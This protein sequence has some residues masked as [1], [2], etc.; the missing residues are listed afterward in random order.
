M[1]II[2]IGGGDKT[3]AVKEALNRTGSEHPSVLLIP[4]ACSTENSYNKKVP[5]LKAFFTQLGVEGTALHEFNK[6]PS[7]DEIAEKIGQ[8]ALLYTIGGNTPFMI[9]TMQEH[10][11][12]TMIKTAIE[13][14]K[15]HAGVSAGALLPFEL[16]HS[17]IAAKPAETDWDY[18]Y[19]PGLGIIPG[20]ATAHADSHDPTPY[21][22]RP[23]SRL[24]ALLNTF[25][26]TIQTG[27]AIDNGAALVFS[28]NS[29]AVITSSPTARVHTIRHSPNNT[30]SYRATEI[31][32]LRLS[33]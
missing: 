23:D 21:G 9:R 14:G 25:P 17:C 27:Y 20:V 10:G 13:H 7:P 18:D 19:I 6:Q 1:E 4:S 11:T 12:D 15:V 16:A 5:L 26:D 30:I 22:L 3:D 8:A 2:A 31:D 28:T 29:P 24:D 33:A 32:D